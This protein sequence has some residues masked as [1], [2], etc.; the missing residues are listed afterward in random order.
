MLELRNIHKS[1]GDV[2]VLDGVN[3]CLKK[4]FV[5]CEEDLL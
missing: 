5:I 1:F 2:R 3:L 4:G